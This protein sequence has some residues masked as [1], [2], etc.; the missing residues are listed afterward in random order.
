VIIKKIRDQKIGKVKEKREAKIIFNLRAEIEGKFSIKNLGQG[1]SRKR[2]KRN[3]KKN[4][5]ER[6]TKGKS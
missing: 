1:I 5:I 3:K 6:K 4:R 2:K